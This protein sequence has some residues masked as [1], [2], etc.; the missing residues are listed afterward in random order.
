MSKPGRL[1]SAQSSPIVLFVINPTDFFPRKQRE[2]N[3]LEKFQQDEAAPTLSQIRRLANKKVDADPCGLVDGGGIF[4]VIRY[5][6]RLNVSNGT[7]DTT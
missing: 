1:G 3:F 2:R 7:A 5:P 6:V 4:G